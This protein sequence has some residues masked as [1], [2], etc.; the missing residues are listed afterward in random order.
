MPHF[1]RLQSLIFLRTNKKTSRFLLK[2]CMCCM[3]PQTLQQQ[4][5][6]QILNTPKWKSA[7]KKHDENKNKKPH[8]VHSCNS[9]KLHKRR[10]E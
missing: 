4:Q 8:R 5:H 1:N 9:K 10:L 3:R 7:T 2:H 6:Q